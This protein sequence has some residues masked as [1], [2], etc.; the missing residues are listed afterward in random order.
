LS[1]FS[2]GQGG[3]GAVGVSCH[4]RRPPRIGRESL[5]RGGSSGCLRRGVTSA[6]ASATIH[7]TIV[8]PRK[9]LN[10]RSDNE[11]RRLSSTAT[12]QGARYMTQAKMAHMLSA[13]P[14]PAAVLRYS[15]AE[16][17]AESGVFCSEGV[18]RSIFNSI[19]PVVARGD[20]CPKRLG[21]CVCPGMMVAVVFRH[22]EKVQDRD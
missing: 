2:G 5:T 9:T 22:F 21:V 13:V 14:R 12:S 8:Q 20:Y 7:P 6:E 1:S 18:A 15:L 11:N 3:N 17:P 16:G 4:S 10:A 19:D